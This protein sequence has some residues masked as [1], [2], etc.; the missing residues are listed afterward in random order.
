MCCEY[1]RWQ[2]VLHNDVG[3]CS[4]VKSDRM[5]RS[6]FVWRDVKSERMRRSYSSCSYDGIKC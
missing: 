4:N 1:Q 5:R 3:K 6:C 2:S